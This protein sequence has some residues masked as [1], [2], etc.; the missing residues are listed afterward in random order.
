M[1]EV[2][3]GVVEPVATMFTRGAW[4]RGWRLLAIDGFD[5]DVPDTPANACEFGYAETRKR[6][7]SA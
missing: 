1:A 7:T 5:V 2:F 3:E 4:L 6:V